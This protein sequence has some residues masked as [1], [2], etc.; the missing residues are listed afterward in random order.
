M[1]DSLQV[2]REVE[3]QG[4]VFLASSSFDRWLQRFG[5]RLFAW[6]VITA[7]GAVYAWA[8]RHAMNPDGIS[9][10]DIAD[11]Y[12]RGD[13]S[14]A[15]N[16]HW[17]PLYPLLLA[18]ALW[19]LK[20]APYAEFATV[21]LLNFIIFLG[22]LASFEFLLSQLMCYHRKFV[23][24]AT[25][26]GR[27]ALPEWSLRMLGYTLFLYA[28]LELIPIPGVS[29]DMLV[30]VFVYLASALLL[31]IGRR[32]EGT[33]TFLLMGV[34]LGL[35][36]LAKAPM[37]PLGVVFLALGA[38]TVYTQFPFSGVVRRLLAALVPFALITCSL[39]LAFFL[40]GQ[41]VTLGESG[42]LNYAW[43][44]NGLPFVHW[45]GEFP[46]S[47]RPVH[48]T[49]EISSSPPVYEFA[50]P[51][52]GTY[53]PWYDPAYWFQGVQLHFDAR[54]HLHNLVRSA[55][56]LFALLY[57]SQGVLVISGLL[58]LY[59]G[60]RGRLFLHDMR[61]YSILLVPALAAVSMFSLIWLEPR[62][63]AAFVTLFWLGLFAPMT[64]VE[65]PEG[66]RVITGVTIAMLALLILPT[67]L[68]Y[69]TTPAIF[70]RQNS[71]PQWTV[72]QGLQH[73]GLHPGDKVAIISDQPGAYGAYWARL[74][75]LRIVAEIPACRAY[76]GSVCTKGQP[77]G[78]ADFLQADQETKER[79]LKIFNKAG[80]EAVVMR[81]ENNTPLHGWRRI[82]DTDYYVYL[83]RI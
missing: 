62:Y 19:V 71:Y 28:S 10:L 7:I 40:T 75:R 4:L 61:P 35:G 18:A 52:G 43:N 6:L 31:K 5:V 29:P 72:A 77:S 59:L 37:L 9:Y 2:E 26:E 11:A 67:P 42:K 47:G 51:I 24:Q 34:V 76:A 45:Q 33:G 74:S 49:R 58:F 8:G 56:V 3:P 22:A 36:Y 79:I 12:S 17:S 20:P 54:S 25:S 57:R 80:A 38:V 53:P 81:N 70:A 64:F 55:R 23:A 65:S 16:R 14:M 44:V 66:R 48:P 21:Q 69:R 15:I 83:L 78:V 1:S 46:G 50:T 41:G 39:V 32:P 68:K 27:F 82:P 73:L 63:I 13:W 30:A 60:R